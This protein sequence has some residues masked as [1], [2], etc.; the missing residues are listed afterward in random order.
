M[1]KMAM[2]SDPPADELAAKEKSR[3]EAEIELEPLR[4]ERFVLIRLKK[5]RPWADRQDSSKP[6]S[7]DS[8]G[9]HG[10]G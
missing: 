5:F 2:W 4:T 3:I 6:P 9:R 1:R 10:G 8:S 7:K